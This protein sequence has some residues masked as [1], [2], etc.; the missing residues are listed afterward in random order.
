MHCHCTLHCLHLH[1][2]DGDLRS[3]GSQR[4]CDLGACWWRDDFWQAGWGKAKCSGKRVG[5]PHLPPLPSRFF[6]LISVVLISS[7]RVQRRGRNEVVWLQLVPTWCRDPGG[8]CSSLSSGAR[9]P[10]LDA[11]PQC[12]QVLAEEVRSWEGAINEGVKL[13]PE[14]LWCYR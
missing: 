6:H 9:V 10:F 14:V 5:F 11:Q 12:R 8:M 13:W 2:R 1:P 7:L 4:R 3:Q